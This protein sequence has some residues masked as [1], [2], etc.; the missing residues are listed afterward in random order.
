MKTKKIVRSNERGRKEGEG[1]GKDI[2]PIVSAVSLLQ[3]AAE[4]LRADPNWPDLALEE[5]SL[6]TGNKETPPTRH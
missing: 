2:L 5:G 4:E 1:K 6:G 3:R